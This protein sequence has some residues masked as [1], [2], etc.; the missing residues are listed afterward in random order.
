MKAEIKK[1]KA[2]EPMTIEIVIENKD[3]LKLFYD[4]L[5]DSKGCSAFSELYK[6]LHNL[7]PELY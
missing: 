7:Y 4:L 2:F 1:E 5:G 6:R 3:D